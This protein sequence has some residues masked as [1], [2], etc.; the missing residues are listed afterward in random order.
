MSKKLVRAAVAAVGVAF[1]L[2][3]CGGGGGLPNYDYQ[4]DMEK[5]EDSITVTDRSYLTLVNKQNP[6]GD[7]YVP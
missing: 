7:G 4:I 2:S 1:L 5:Y 3:S 6:C